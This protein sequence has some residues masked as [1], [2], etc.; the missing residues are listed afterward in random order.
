LPNLRPFL[1][2]GQLLAVDMQPW[3]A[4]LQYAITQNPADATLALSR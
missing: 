2:L 1:K 3:L 4:L